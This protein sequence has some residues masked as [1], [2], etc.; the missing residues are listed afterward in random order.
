[1]NWFNWDLWRTAIRLT[2]KNVFENIRRIEYR[3]DIKKTFE[4]II[5]L[6][7]L[8]P[9]NVPSLL[10]QLACSESDDIEAGELEDL[11]ILHT[12]QFRSRRRGASLLF[13]L[14][15]AYEKAKD[16]GSVPFHA[17]ESALLRALIKCMRAAPLKGHGLSATSSEDKSTL[18]A[19][20]QYR[21]FGKHISFTDIYS[22]NSE[23]VLSKG[24]KSYTMISADYAFDFVRYAL[25]TN[26]RQ[27]KRCVENSHLGVFSK[28][29]QS[30]SLL[31][32]GLLNFDEKL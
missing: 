21:V 13:I 25:F 1:M 20:R 11:H 7:Y 29:I 2:V 22:E 17:S 28:M 8:T 4:H 27:V 15:D 31:L 18:S 5:Q 12:E 32:Q 9:E 14:R 19:E 30:A 23:N 6:N 10:M 24:R 3:D 26:Y 16:S